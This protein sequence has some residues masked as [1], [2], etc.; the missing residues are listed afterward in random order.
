MKT[1][2][3]PWPW[4]AGGE[5][6][7]LPRGA[8]SHPTSLQGQGVSWDRQHWWLWLCHVKLAELLLPEQSSLNSPV[9][10]LIGGGAER[11]QSIGIWYSRGFL[12]PCAYAEPE[13]RV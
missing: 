2:C 1:V 6:A 5:T 7:A 11:E 8:G 13:Q 10:A 3:Q 4:G 12:A 9:G